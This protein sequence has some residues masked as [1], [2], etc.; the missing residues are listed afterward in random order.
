MF[1]KAIMTLFSFLL[2]IFLAQ[3][4]A[5]FFGISFT[6]YSTYL[7]WICGL[8]IFYYILPEKQFIF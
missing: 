6:D 4:I 1:F 7:F 5:N 8:V 2:I 3:V